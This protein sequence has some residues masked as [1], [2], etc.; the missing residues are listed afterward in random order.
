[1]NSLKDF[2]EQ[3]IKVSS[4]IMMVFFFGYGYDNGGGPMMFLGSSS[5]ESISYEIFYQKMD[6]FQR[7]DDDDNDDDND[8]HII[9]FT[10]ICIKKPTVSVV[11]TRRYVKYLANI[12]HFCTEV[13]GMCEEGSLMTHILLNDM[14]EDLPF[15]KMAR[16]LSNKINAIG[17]WNEDEYYSYRRCITTKIITIPSLAL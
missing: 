2:Q 8:N 15:N 16:E 17:N 1:M 9:L 12:Y 14:K 4:K 11:E 7:K 13:A 6:E 5:E 3:E 10:N